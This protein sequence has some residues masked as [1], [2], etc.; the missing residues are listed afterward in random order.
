[1]Q[2]ILDIITLVIASI[3]GL[4]I[5]YGVI[6]GIIELVQVEWQRFR[7]RDVQKSFSFEKIRNDIGFH[8][9]LG[10]EFLIAA[11]II[12]TIIRPSL[13]ELAILGGIVLIR[14]TIS[15]FLGREMN[16]KKRTGK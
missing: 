11:D 15:Y 7:T 8:L 10:L 9:L 12:R 6:L 16:Q 1:M 2:E 14:T 4:V 5:L 13:E 3:A